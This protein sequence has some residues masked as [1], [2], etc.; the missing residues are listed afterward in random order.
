MAENRSMALEDLSLRVDVRNAMPEKGLAGIVGA[1]ERQV[2]FD[3]RHRSGLEGFFGKFE[4][5]VKFLG[6]EVGLSQAGSEMRAFGKALKSEGVS[7]EIQEMFKTELEGRTPDEQAEFLSGGMGSLKEVALK[8]MKIRSEAPELS[9]TEIAAELSRLGQEYRSATAKD[10]E[11]IDGFMKKMLS[12][13]KDTFNATAGMWRAQEDMDVVNRVR[14]SVELGHPDVKRG[15]EYEFTMEGGTIRKVLSWVSR[16]GKPGTVARRTTQGFR[17]A[18]VRDKQ[19]TWARLDFLKAKA[20]AI[21]GEAEDVAMWKA[22]IVSTKELGKVDVAQLKREGVLTEKQ[23]QVLSE[24]KE[25]NKHLNAAGE[26][27]RTSE[28]N[29]YK[30]YNKFFGDRMSHAED[31]FRVSR[32]RYL[33]FDLENLKDE[34]KWDVVGGAAGVG[35][36]LAPLPRWFKAGVAKVGSYGVRGVVSLGTGLGEGVQFAVDS[37][38]STIA[39]DALEQMTAVALS[40]KLVTDKF[41]ELLKSE[42][43]DKKTLLQAARV[44]RGGWS[45]FE[46]EAALYAAR[47]ADTVAL[48]EGKS[49]P[50][51]VLLSPVEIA[52]GGVDVA[53]GGAFFGEDTARVATELKKVIRRSVDGQGVMEGLKSEITL[54]PK[55]LDNA[56]VDQWFSERVQ[57]LNIPDEYLST[58]GLEEFMRR[59]LSHGEAIERFRRAVGPEGIFPEALSGGS[60]RQ[61]VEQIRQK[62]GQQM[63]DV[64]SGLDIYEAN[65]GTNENPHFGVEA[66]TVVVLNDALEH[67]A[68]V[69]LKQIGERARLDAMEN[70]VLEMGEPVLKVAKVAAAAAL[71]HL[72]SGPWSEGLHVKLAQAGEALKGFMDVYNANVASIPDIVNPVHESWATVGAEGTK[73]GLQH[74][75]WLANLKA[76]IAGGVDTVIVKGGLLARAAL[77]VGGLMMAYRGGKELLTGKVK[78]RTALF[79]PSGVVK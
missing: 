18:A 6:G 26:F 5:A 27:T 62:V 30:F 33:K 39:K 23:A 66:A 45:V 75:V 48:S 4:S 21:G 61:S 43:T 68:L 50:M 20:L 42:S 55:A 56:K 60:R 59:G 7:N 77:G 44:V 36:D 29:E 58:E 19:E 78:P 38:E 69:D 10:R 3:R 32:E 40:R 64:K 49:L 13:R 35:V 16:A 12:A 25:L 63:R 74:A 28:A 22:G 37:V 65:V 52:R 34:N 11:A 31:F 47:A 54:R 15:D 41:K 79:A 24:G 8:L 73:A 46:R 57:E 17:R 2:R 70:K 51:S 53:L 1:T 14:E 72:V 71:I 67:N 76:S 9:G